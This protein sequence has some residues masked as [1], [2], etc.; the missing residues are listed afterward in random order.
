MIFGVY[1]CPIEFARDALYGVIRGECGHMIALAVFDRPSW[2]AEDEPLTRVLIE[3][4]ERVER[5]R[6]GEP[7]K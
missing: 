2:G 4:L 3:G 7:K 5:E 1:T 6:S